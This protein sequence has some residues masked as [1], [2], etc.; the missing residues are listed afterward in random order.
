MWVKICGVSNVESAIVVADAG[1]DAL[2][3][4]FVGRSKRRISTETAGAIADAV[5]GRLELVAVVEDW[6]VEEA[7]RLRDQLKLDRVQFHS[8]RSVIDESTLPD[9]AYMASGLS[10]PSDASALAIPTQRWILVD[11]CVGGISG[12]TGSTFDWN[13]VK[14]VAVER[15]LILAGGLGVANVVD[16]I[17][18]AQPFG[19]DVASGVEPKNKPGIKDPDLVCE[20]VRRARGGPDKA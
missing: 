8:A 1:A 4:N 16:A 2:G 13:W 15:P 17:A 7:A 14:S 19:V 3:L 18:T 10:T 12:G 20:F 6:T 5:R 9:W 11:A